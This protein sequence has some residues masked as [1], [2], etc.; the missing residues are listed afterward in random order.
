MATYLRAWD[1]TTFRAFKI[2]VMR[3]EDGLVAEVTTSGT[4]LFPAFRLPP[5]L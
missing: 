3:V 1:D 2:D 5:I 4:S